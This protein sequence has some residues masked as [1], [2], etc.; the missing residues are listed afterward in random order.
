MLEGWHRMEVESRGVLVWKGLRQVSLSH[1]NVL[2][3]GFYFIFYFFALC[4]IVGSQTSYFSHNL[5]RVIKEKSLKYIHVWSPPLP[6]QILPC[7]YLLSLR[8]YSETDTAGYPLLSAL[9]LQIIGRL[10]H[11]LGSPLRQPRCSWS[12]ERETSS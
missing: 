6:L 10:C 9:K 11:L 1:V 4:L 3:E 7:K 12:L 8:P 2:L 5:I